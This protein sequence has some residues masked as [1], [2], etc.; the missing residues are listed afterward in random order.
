[1][2]DNESALK[3]DKI[4]SFFE[5]RFVIY[6]NYEALLSHL[7]N[8]LDS[9]FFGD[10]SIHWNKIASRVLTGPT[11]LRTKC[12]TIKEALSLVD[13]ATIASYFERD[14]ITDH[15]R[16]ST[17][18]IDSILNQGILC[19]G[20]VYLHCEQLRCYLFDLIKRRKPIPKLSQGDEFIGPLWETYKEMLFHEELANLERK[21]RA[22]HVEL[23]SRL[24]QNA[25]LH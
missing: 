21:K 18:I 19:R 20:K 23:I 3:C 17:D 14:G 8:P 13:F 10:L 9:Y 4:K 25:G 11:D 24:R 2:V 15:R 6:I 7:C 5:D 12:Q 1:M 16:S 22:R